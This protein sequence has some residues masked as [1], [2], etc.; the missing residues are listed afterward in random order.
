MPLHIVFN[1]ASY[2]KGGGKSL[3]DCLYADPPL[4][5]KLHNLF[6][7]FRSNSFAVI[8]DISKAF[9]RVIVHPE[10]RKWTKFLR[11]NLERE[12]Q[13]IYQ[14][15]V[16]IFGSHSSPFILSQVLETHTSSRA[17]P[18]CNLASY[19]YVDSLVKTYEDESELISGKVV[20][21]SVL[22]EANMPLRGWISN[23]QKFND[24]YQ[25]NERSLQ[26][27]LGISWNVIS[28]CIAMVVSKKF[29]VKLSSWKA[30]KRNFLSALVA[31]FDPLGLIAPLVLAGKLLLQQLWPNKVGWDELLSTEYNQIALNFLKDLSQ[32]GIF[33]FPRKAVTL[34]SELH[35]FVDSSSKA[36]GAVA[37]SYYRR[38]NDSK[39]LTSKQRVTPCGKKKLTIPKLELTATLVGARLARHLMTLFDFSPITLWTDGSVILSWL[40]HL[41]NLKDVYVSNRIVELRYLIDACTIHMHHIS[42]KC[43]P[44]DILSRGCTLKQLVNHQLWLHGPVCTMFLLTPL[45]PLNCLL[46]T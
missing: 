21:D 12:V 9:H 26:M 10:H 17:K 7:T 40:N 25:V 38:T 20:I 43:N 6:L 27:V 16:V 28:H 33:E 30:T 8:S 41:Y 39:L 35:I 23:S 31:I 32:T 44:A 13:L 24:T 29:P 22:E 19:F 42:T 46:C 5:T 18:I 36:S 14:F 45:L 2:S 15:N 34:H 3:N 1:A 37:Y 11:V 4:T